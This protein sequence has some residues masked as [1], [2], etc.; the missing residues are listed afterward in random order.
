M[1]IDTSALTP[2]EQITSIYISYYNRAPDPWVWSSGPASSTPASRSRISR[3]PSRAPLKPSRHSRIADPDPSAADRRHLRHLDLQ[4]PVR[5]HPDQDGLDFWSDQ[6]TS[7]STP[8]GQILLEF[9][10]GAR[11]DAAAGTDDETTVRNKIDVGADW[12]ASAAAA[13]IGTTEGSALAVDNGDG[14]FTVNNQA[15]FDSASTILDNVTGDPATV[16]AA[17]EAT[18]AFTGGAAGAPTELGAALGALSD[19]QDARTE[20]LETDA[21]ANEGVAELAGAGAETAA[22]VDVTTHYNDASLNV[23]GALGAVAGGDF[24]LNNFADRSANV[25][26]AAIADGVAQAQQNVADAE[27]AVADG[28]LP[29]LDTLQAREATLEE[30]IAAEATAEQTFLGELARFNQVNADD[31][32][33]VIADPNNLLADGDTLELGGATI[34]TL[35]DGSWEAD[36]NF[37]FGA[38]GRNRTKLR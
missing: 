5:T 30:A 31:I 14:T 11:D 17:K 12:A 6:L 18:A 29:A 2:Q 13:D 34:A 27:E 9:I 4:Q 26:D 21:L 33:P 16:T 20:F 1:P 15:A 10:E 19:A 37:D 3:P 8:V 23:D 28:V 36:T 22:E 24:T 35:V 38:A 32:T 25:Q 7:G